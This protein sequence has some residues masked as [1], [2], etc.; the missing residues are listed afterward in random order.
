MD[1]WLYH[2]CPFFSGQLPNELKINQ[3]QRKYI[4][5][6]AV[7]FLVFLPV[8]KNTIQTELKKIY[9][10][11]NLKKHFNL[12]FSSG[13]LVRGPCTRGFLFLL[14]CPQKFQQWPGQS[15]RSSP[16]SFGWTWCFR[17]A[18]GRNE[19]TSG[20]VPPHTGFD[21]AHLTFRSLWTKSLEWKYSTPLTICLKI[22]RLS[23][24]LSWLGFSFFLRIHDLRFLEEHSSISI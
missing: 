24:F 15:L 3:A 23:S 7:R 9:G 2:L 21:G 6:S 13:L 4:H 8:T 5:F 1:L 10:H 12:S 18:V 20:V 16:L 11:N 17:A 22:E 14:F 19:A